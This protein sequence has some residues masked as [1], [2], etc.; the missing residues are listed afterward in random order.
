M[1][2]DE[3]FNNTIILHNHINNASIVNN[4]ALLSYISEIRL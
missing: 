4:A 3:N 2:V 1:P